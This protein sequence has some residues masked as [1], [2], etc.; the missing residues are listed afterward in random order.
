MEGGGGGG[1]GGLVK[2]RWIW[3]GAVP[4]IDFDHVLQMERVCGRVCVPSGEEGGCG[5]SSEG[6]DRIKPGKK[7]E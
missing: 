3:P 7:G 4:V 1:V 2:H 5:G 6:R